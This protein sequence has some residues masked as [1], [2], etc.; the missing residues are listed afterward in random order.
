MVSQIQNKDYALPL[1]GK[2]KSNFVEIVKRR[3]TV[4]NFIPI[5]Q[6]TWQQVVI[7]AY[8]KPGRTATG[9]IKIVMWKDP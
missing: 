5:Y 3:W 7:E 2:L 1:L 9:K 4:P 8:G 6:T